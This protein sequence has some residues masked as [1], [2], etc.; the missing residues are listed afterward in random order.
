MRRLLIS[1][2]LFALALG[3]TVSRQVEEPPPPVGEHDLT[4]RDDPGGMEKLAKTDPVAFLERVVDKYDKEVRSFRC[5]L[6]KQERVKGKL[7]PRE[8]ID[9]RFREKPFSVRMDWKEEDRGERL[10]RGLTDPTAVLYVEGENGGKLLARALGLVVPRDPTGSQAKASSRY[11]ITEFGIQIGTKRTLA[12]WKAAKEKGELK[13]EFKGVTK[14]KELNDRPAWELRRTGYQAEDEGGVAETASTFYFDVENWLQVGSYL[15][16][17]EGKLV[18]Y[19]YFRDLE[20][21]VDLPDALF[22][23]DALKGK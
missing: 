1:L 21:N 20:L 9:C 22:T 8:V 6:E 23:K 17:E 13:V 14:L 18:A 12:S 19:Y 3:C 15:T 5:T 7:F 11:P 16:G 10:K 4:K 2:P